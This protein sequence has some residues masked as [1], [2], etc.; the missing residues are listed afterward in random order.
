MTVVCSYA[1]LQKAGFATTR[2]PNGSGAF[3]GS[4]P[5]RLIPTHLWERQM[6]YYTHSGPV[7]GLH[8]PLL[9]SNPK[10]NAKAK[11]KFFLKNEDL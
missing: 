7:R 5:P 8:Q 9:P 3:G 4:Q 11:H 2:V 1:R 10:L 6:G